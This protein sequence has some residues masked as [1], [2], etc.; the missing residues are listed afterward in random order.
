MGKLWCGARETTAEAIRERA[1]RAAS[2]LEHLGVREGD[3][4]AFCLRNEFAFFEVVQAAGILGAFPVA[5]NW[6]C[7]LDEADYVLRDCG[8][9]VLVIHAD[10]LANLRAA[11][12]EGVRVISVR[13]PTEVRAAYGLAPAAGQPAPGDLEWGA[14][15]EGFAPWS[16]EARRAPSVIIYTSGTTGR[17]KGVKRGAATEEQAQAS[18][19]MLL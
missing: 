16:G 9:R 7:T 6:H 17:P 19:A 1:Q 10:L 4:V 15:L 14:W 8:A 11:I 13:T 5:V 3:A 18:T 12:S 2:G